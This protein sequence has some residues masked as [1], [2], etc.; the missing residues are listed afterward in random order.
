M[1]NNLKKIGWQA[2]ELG[3]IVVLLS[4]VLTAILGAEGGVVIQAI[5]KNAMTLLKEIPSGTTIG[6][7]ALFGLFALYDKR[8][9]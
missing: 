1:L 4:I 2:I 6:L 9:K 8:N 3:A 5:A 7:V